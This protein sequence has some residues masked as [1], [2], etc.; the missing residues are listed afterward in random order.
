VERLLTYW[1]FYVGVILIIESIA[2]FFMMG[3][4]KF[5]RAQTRKQREIGVSIRKAREAAASSS[6][7]CRFDGGVWHKG[8]CTKFACPSMHNRPTM[9]VPHHANR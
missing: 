3:W 8:A 4:Y 7:P 5:Y 1:W 9:G 2:I 6:H